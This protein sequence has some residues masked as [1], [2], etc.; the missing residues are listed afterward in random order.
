MDN[1]HIISIKAL[2]HI[3]DLSSSDLYWQGG[4]LLGI[5]GLLL[6]IRG[7]LLGIGGFLLGIGGLL[8][9]KADS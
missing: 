2:C 9:G 6:G 7:L 1:R 5:G 8:I 3:W 4:L